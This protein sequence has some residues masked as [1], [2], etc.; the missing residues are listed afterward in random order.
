VDF[1]VDDAPALPI[2]DNY[3]IFRFPQTGQLVTST[4]I[5]FGRAKD[6]FYY[7]SG[8]ARRMLEST[9]YG[10]GGM[11]WGQFNGFEGSGTDQHARFLYFFVGTEEQ[12]RDPSLNGRGDDGLPRVGHGGSPL[13]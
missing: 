10:D 6:E 9:E 7:Y 1:R 8:D 3:Y 13:N 2:E 12:F 11:I 4:D 5:E